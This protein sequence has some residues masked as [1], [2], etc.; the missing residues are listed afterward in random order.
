M[1]CNIP[2]V[3]GSCECDADALECQ[4]KC[5]EG[6]LGPMCD[7]RCPRDCSGH[8]K[9]DEWGRCKCNA[10]W[11]G[12]DCSQPGCP[13]DCSQH[14]TCNHNHTCTCEEG[15]RGVDCGKLECPEACNWRTHQGECLFDRCSCYPGFTGEACEIPMPAKD[16]GHP[17]GE[18]CY[19]YCRANAQCEGA[20]E[21]T[22]VFRNGPGGPQEVSVPTMSG[23]LLDAEVEAQT[24]KLQTNT[25]GR[26]CYLHCLQNCFSDC[27]A[28]VHT[29]SREEREEAAR[30]IAAQINNGR[31][32]TDVAMHNITGDVADAER[33]NQTE[34]GISIHDISEHLADEAR[35]AEGTS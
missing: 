4:C 26:K 21:Q 34:A 19:E 7:R 13:N 1:V 29:L 20:E 11:T 28:D 3:H 14:G 30:K 17:C 2:C 12:V 10:R 9:C 6:F 5:D 18:N 15:W 22:F 31:G 27:F 32:A 8:G 25:Q 23:P 16:E 35:E 33:T 24:G